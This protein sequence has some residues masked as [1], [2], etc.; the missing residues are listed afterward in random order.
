[1]ERPNRNKLIRWVRDI[2]PQDKLLYIVSQ[3][4]DYIEYLRKAHKGKVKRLKSDHEKQIDEITG[5]SSLDRHVEKVKSQHLDLEENVSELQL[6]LTESKK[7]LDTFEKR[8]KI[9]LR[10]TK[11]EEE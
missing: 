8:N 7:A 10:C 11:E 1:M 5:M 2:K 3:Y 9:Y 4:E 6:D